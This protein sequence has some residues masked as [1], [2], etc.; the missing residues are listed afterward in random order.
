[1]DDGSVGV[2][3]TGYSKFVKRIFINLIFS[4]ATVYATLGED[5]IK[6]AIDETG[7]TSIVTSHELIPTVAVCHFIV[8]C[9]LN[10]RNNFEENNRQMQINKACHLYGIVA[11][12]SKSC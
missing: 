1:L 12:K 3:E 10:I 4:V 9:M 7:A 8:K 11:T 5:A 6:H 2:L